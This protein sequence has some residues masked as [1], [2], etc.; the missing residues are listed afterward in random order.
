MIILVGGSSGS[1]KT[2]FCKNLETYATRHGGLS[3]TVIPHDYYYRDLS[4]LSMEERMQVNFDHPD[5]L[6]TPR[7]VNDL[8][9]LNSLE[10]NQIV[11]PK[12]NYKTHTSDTTNSI[13]IKTSDV[14]IVEGILVLE[15]TELKKIADL[16]VYIDT[17]RDICLSRRI[18]RDTDTR[19]R[20][21]DQIM[22]QYFGSVREMDNTYVRVGRETADIIINGDN[23][24]KENQSMLILGWVFSTILKRHK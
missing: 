15:N 3:V 23:R 4:H 20:R 17:S 1:G 9:R 16:S 8:T 22:S 12:Y 2:T 13:T 21:P 11:L 5:S 6:D 7:L 10:V 14:Y 24:F 19:A 18:L